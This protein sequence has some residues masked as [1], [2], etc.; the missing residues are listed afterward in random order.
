MPKNP[1]RTFGR[2]KSSSNI[3]DAHLAASEPKLSQDPEPTGFRV[4]DRPPKNAAPSTNGSQAARV[5]SRR[6]FNSPLNHLRLGKSADDL[7]SFTNRYANLSCILSAMLNT[8]MS[9]FSGSG[10]TTHSGSSYNYDS[11][12]AR[13][14]SSSTLPS[15]VDPERDPDDEDLFP[16]KVKSQPMNHAS[17][18]APLPPPP[19]FTARATRAFSFGSRSSRP[20]PEKIPPV[21]P[22]HHLQKETYAQDDLANR[23]RATTVSSYA[24]TAIP[25]SGNTNSSGLQIAGLSSSFGDDFGSMF[26]GLGK[27]SPQIE[28]QN[29]DL[30]PDTTHRTV[31]DKRDCALLTLS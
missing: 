16:R 22:I 2:R 20:E 11:S 12:S 18:D 26:A 27:E 3:L 8:D 7:G 6:P 21:P 30:F 1:L 29:R 5:G 28:A 17:L 15:S 4:L 19:S 9:T 13:H 25:S 31:S 14:S 23:D 10:G 24:S